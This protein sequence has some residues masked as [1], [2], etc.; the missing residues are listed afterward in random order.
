MT[1]GKNIA[2]LY[3]DSCP[4]GFGAAYSAW[5]KLGDTADYIP[6]KHQEPPPEGLAGKDLYFLD[7]CYGQPTMDIFLKNAKSLVVVDHHEGVQSVI[8]S[9]PKHVYSTEHSGATLAWAYFHPDTPIPLFLQYVEDADLFRMLPDEERAIIT[10]TYAQP[11]RFDVWDENVRRVADPI[12]RAK[13]VERGTGYREYFQL[14]SRQLADSAELVTFEGYTCYLVSGEKMFI[15][16]LANQLRI[17]HPP[18]ALVA[19]VIPTGLR[20]S[21]RGDDTVDVAELA[22][23]Y[24]G[25]GH[26]NSAAFSIPWGAPLPWK[27]LPPKA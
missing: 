18:F 20:I 19:R 10:Y 17:K 22:S 26:F 23:R 12:E 1:E 25:N 7:F 8:E 15:T 9:M 21:L 13:I 27:P 3:H 24:G 14:L 16:E 4:D 6:V 5:K 2:V 11:R